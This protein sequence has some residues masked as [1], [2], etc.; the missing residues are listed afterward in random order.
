MS[1]ADRGGGGE[2]STVLQ[3]QLEKT[4]ATAGRDE[5]DYQDY[6]LASLKETW[7]APDDNI[8]NFAQLAEWAGQH[9]DCTDIEEDLIHDYMP[10]MVRLLRDQDSLNRSELRPTDAVCNIAS[11]R[12][13]L[14]CV[15]RGHV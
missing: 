14:Q 7:N 11:Q 9:G 12:C 10:Q 15:P 13:A 8:N 5:L 6:G 1:A 3:S 4:S 2:R